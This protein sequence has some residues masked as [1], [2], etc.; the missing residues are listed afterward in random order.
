[1]SRKLRTALITFAVFLA[2][3]L[4]TG[5]VSLA[6]LFI[7]F[8]FIG[9]VYLASRFP[10]AG[11]IGGGLLLLGSPLV[12]WKLYNPKFFYTDG[13]PAGLVLQL[14]FV[15]IVFLMMVLGWSMLKV[16]LFPEPKLTDDE[17]AELA[18]KIMDEADR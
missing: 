10:V 6:G 15:G 11:S 12:A 7:V 13:S 16:A 5:G 8:V 3:Q 17:R 18:M 4:L 1:M 9:V 2:F 14:I